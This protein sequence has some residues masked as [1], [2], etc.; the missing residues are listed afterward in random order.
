MAKDQMWPAFIF[1][2]KL[3]L[4]HSHAHLLNLGIIYGCFYT[5]Y[6]GKVVAKETDLQSMNFLLFRLHRKL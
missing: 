3:L 6:I 5:H 2:N 4:K 1:V